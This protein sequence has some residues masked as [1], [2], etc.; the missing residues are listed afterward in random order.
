[1]TD[2]VLEILIDPSGA[3]AGAA[4]AVRALDDIRSRAAE[5]EGGLSD[6]GRSL[7][8]SL[9]AAARSL[10]GGAG[11]GGPAGRRRGLP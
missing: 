5:A 3:E 7:G 8:G 6:L 4:R 2:A 11:G 10:G 9:E 1:M